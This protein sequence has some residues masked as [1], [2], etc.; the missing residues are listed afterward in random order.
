MNGATGYPY[1]Y[2][3]IIHLYYILM[4]DILKFQNFTLE[5]E[6]QSS[7]FSKFWVYIEFIDV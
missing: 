4:V 3:L 1:N 2:L 7:S 6:F 5:N